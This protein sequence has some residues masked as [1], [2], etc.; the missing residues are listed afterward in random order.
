[1]EHSRAAIRLQ[2]GHGASAQRDKGNVAPRLFK[3]VAYLVLGT[4]NCPPLLLYLIL[5][6]PYVGAP[7]S[8]NESNSSCIS[9]HQAKAVQVDVCN[10]GVP[11]PWN[12]QSL[13][14]YQL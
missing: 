14:T 7:T 11:E 1:M 4:V 12:L 9:Q 3:H 10:T 6:K 2:I 13:T 5:V 8:C